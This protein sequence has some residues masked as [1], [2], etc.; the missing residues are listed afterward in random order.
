MWRPDEESRM[1][2]AHMHP[3]TQR[4]RPTLL[5]IDFM[6]GCDLWARSYDKTAGVEGSRAEFVAEQESWHCDSQCE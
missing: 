3:R 1:E 2:G 6:K 5:M 4:P